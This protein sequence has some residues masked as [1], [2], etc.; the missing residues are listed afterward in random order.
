R[1][2][3]MLVDRILFLEGVPEI[4]RYET[5]RVGG[6]VEKQFNNDLS[7]EAKTLQ[8][9]N[10]AVQ[11]SFDVQDTGSRLLAETLLVETENQLDWLESQ[12][13]LIN[14]VGLQNYLAHQIG[15]INAA[16]S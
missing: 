16:T 3:Q 11:T 10:A 13:D 5:I 4:G 12:I 8:A 14:K 7:L 6:S 9:Y 15:T 1:H 2:S